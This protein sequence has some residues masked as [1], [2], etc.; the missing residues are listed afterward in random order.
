MGIRTHH[1]KEYSGTVLVGDGG[2]YADVREAFAAG[3]KIISLI[4]DVTETASPAINNY[5]KI[6]CN[7]YTLTCNYIFTIAGGNVE[8]ENGTFVSNYVGSAGTELL[9]GNLR[10]RY[11]TLNFSGIT[12]YSVFS[13][14][15]NW[16]SDFC[17]LKLSTGDGYFEL[18]KGYFKNGTIQ[19]NSAGGNYTKFKHTLVANFVFD[20]VDFTG[21]WDTS[22]QWNYQ[23]FHTGNFKFYKCDNTS[24]YYIGI[25]K[26]CKYMEGCQ[27]FQVSEQGTNFY[28]IVSSKGITIAPWGTGTAPKIIDCENII[29]K[30]GASDADFSDTLIIE[31]SDV[32]FNKSSTGGLT[33]SGGLNVSGGSVSGNGLSAANFVKN[34]CNFENV[35]INDYM[36]LPE[37]NSELDSCYYPSS[38]PLSITGNNISVSDTRFGLVNGGFATF[39]IGAAANKTR[40]NNCY[41]EAAYT[42][43]GTGSLIDATP[44]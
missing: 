41:Y 36:T 21:I 34:R 26:A 9:T 28:D 14:G 16:Y 27:N 39:N 5:I 31:N 23:A 11:V 3:E 22:I 17:T 40:V 7:G 8:I 25:Y 15:L 1:A 37:D 29:I 33:L 10:S 13:A 32:E 38:T 35:D 2:K 19:G 44:Y 30:I 20:T 4:S 42:D 24:G 43:S 18:N 6:E 12:A